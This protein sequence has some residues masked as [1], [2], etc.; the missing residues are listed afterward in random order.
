MRHLYFGFMFMLMVGCAAPRHVDTPKPVSVATVPSSK[1]VETFKFIGPET[2]MPRVF[3]AV[4]HED[5]DLGSGLMIY[6]YRLKDGTF[7]WIGTTSPSHIVYVRHGRTMD[8]NELLYP[9]R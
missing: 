6:E 4:G 8:E 1:T 7:V 5:R 2:T 3:A 9:K